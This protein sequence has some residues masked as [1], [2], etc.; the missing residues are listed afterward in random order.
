MYSRKYS[1]IHDILKGSAATMDNKRGIEGAIIQYPPRVK[2]F[3]FPL[4]NY[5]K[6][7]TLILQNA[8]FHAAKSIFPLKNH[9]K[10]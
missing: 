1:L 4:D 10:Y 8:A 2:L 7:T 9:F 6:S 3:C 5:C